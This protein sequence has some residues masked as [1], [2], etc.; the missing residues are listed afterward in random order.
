M[1]ILE[2]DQR[3]MVVFQLLFLIAKHNVK[4]ILLWICVDVVFFK[5]GRKDFLARVVHADAE[6]FE[7]L[8]V[9]AGGGWGG[10]GIQTGFGG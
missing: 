3:Y 7:Y 6:F 1:V 5:G 4:G 2:F 10:R 8:D 9:V